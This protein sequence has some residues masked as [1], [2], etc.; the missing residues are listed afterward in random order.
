MRIKNK[1]NLPESK[2]SLYKNSS[3]IAWKWLFERNGP[4]RTHTWNGYF[5]D[6]EH[7]PSLSNRV[8]ITPVELAKYLSENPEF[9]KNANIH[10]PSLL[11]YA[12]SAFKTEGMDAMNEQLWCFKPMGSHTARYA[13][14]CALWFEQ[15]GNEWF[16]EQAF[17]QLN[18]ASYM[19]YD[20]GVVATGPG[21][22]ATWFSDGYSDYIRHFLDALA[23]IPEWAPSD[24]NHLLRSSSIVQDI[25]YEDKKIEYSTFDINS[26]EKFR[27]VDK[28]IKVMVGNR[29]IE[30]KSSLKDEG[31][32]W[33][34]LDKGGVLS[35]RNL[36]DS[37]LTK[38]IY[39]K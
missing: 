28:P 26:S 2:Y 4:L 22:L 12:L 35:I 15:T 18:T 23:A 8:Q 11:Y 3:E 39:L 29:N 10:V 25:R 1:I 14:A 17:R 37:S 16:K 5:E 31:W 36:S 27:L 19:T 7:D 34:R 38:T 6:V 32:I 20:N 24:E 30:E 9:D 33:E 13:S 21:Y